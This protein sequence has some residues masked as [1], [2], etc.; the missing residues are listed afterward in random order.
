MYSRVK[1]GAYGEVM[2]LYPLHRCYNLWFT[3]CNCMQLNSQAMYNETFFP[4]A[5]AT[6]GWNYEHVLAP[7]ETPPPAHGRC[8]SIVRIHVQRELSTYNNMQATGYPANKHEHAHT[9]EGV[10]T[11]Y[12]AS[13]PGVSYSQAPPSYTQLQHQQG[14]KPLTASEKALEKASTCRYTWF[15]SSCTILIF[16]FF[17]SAATPAVIFVLERL[18]R[19]CP[20][21]VEW[22]EEQ[23]RAHTTSKGTEVGDDIIRPW[24]PTHIMARDS[25]IKNKAWWR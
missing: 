12:P 7:R 3:N 1:Y 20:I 6:S 23:S 5:F 14:P 10:P 18:G 9:V 8:Q 19:R 25:I 22:R 13:Y 2:V 15:H 16:H 24:K 11:A 4:L 21:R 17:G